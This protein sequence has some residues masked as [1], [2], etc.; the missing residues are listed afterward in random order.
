MH[1]YDWQRL[2]YPTDSDL[3]LEPDGFL[4]DPGSSHGRY[5]NQ[6]AKR[7]EELDDI[8]CLVLL[9]E[10]GMG[11]TRSL[12]RSQERLEIAGERTQSLSLG[13]FSSE[14]RLLSKIFEHTSFRTWREV[15][16]IHHLFLDALDEGMT[17]VS[18]LHNLLV[19]ELED[20]TSIPERKR[21]RL[22]ITCR[23]GLWPG[24][25]EQRLKEVWPADDSAIYQLAPLQR[26]D[27][28]KAAEQEGVDADDFFEKVLESKAAPLAARPITLRMLLELY[29]RD[30]RLPSSQVELYE[31]GCRLLCSEPNPD[32]RD[33]K[34]TGQLD[35]EERL[36][37]ASRIAA[38]TVFGHR[39][40]ILLDDVKPPEDE[41][42]AL[43][44]I[45]G[46]K[47]QGFTI[48]ERDLHDVVEY[49]TLFTG[50]GARRMEWA[51]Q[52]YAE[53]LAAMYVK[54]QGLDG[55]R[56]L[57]L[58]VHPESPDMGIAPQHEGTAVWLACMYGEIFTE[59]LDQDPATLVRTD[60]A[61]M[62]EEQKE[63]LVAAL[64]KQEEARDPEML[65]F[66]TRQFHQ[67]DHP[68]LDEKLAPFLRNP[69]RAFGARLTAICLADRC[70]CKDLL[71]EL[72]RLALDAEEEVNLRVSSIAALGRSGDPVVL[73]RLR[74]LLPGD[75]GSEDDHRIGANVI[76]A[77]WPDALS[78]EELFETL[79]RAEQSCFLGKYS[80]LFRRNQDLDLRP[81][82]YHWLWPGW[83]QSERTVDNS[84]GRTGLFF[85]QSSTELGP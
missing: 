42:L 65:H 22:R 82:N 3:Y 50:A 51:H 29:Y 32:R 31:K 57:A 20:R 83:R 48:R 62:K 64:L 45:L 33:R 28:K 56:A 74:S 24:T 39:R 70:K 7:L 13:H 2:W 8:P 16:D 19:D 54:D 26:R 63:Q 14:T 81:V 84:N 17:A 4:V 52:T 59:L 79:R 18:A 25:L 36:A 34:E 71:Q 21:L 76:R 72:L 46:G 77:L 1:E 38:A 47:Q 9:G 66:D 73:R 53:F 41:E 5:F 78:A 37:Y 58:L 55:L 67:L 40:F 6:E 75:R 15:G 35:A 12:R 80:S 23:T 44:E 60:L 68:G 10:P 30:R 27:V 85:F 11:K 61:M 43:P 69:K 49:S